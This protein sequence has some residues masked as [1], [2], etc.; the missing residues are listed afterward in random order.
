MTLIDME[1]CGL[2]QPRVVSPKISQA[3]ALA[4]FS[5]YEAA[6]EAALENIEFEQTETRCWAASQV[7]ERCEAR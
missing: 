6:R 5:R 2:S 4:R 7:C 3:K 1:G